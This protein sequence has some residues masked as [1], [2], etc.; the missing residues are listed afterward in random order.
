MHWIINST[1]KGPRRV[2]QAAVFCDNTIYSF[3]GYSHEVSLVELKFGLPID[4][5]A[6][7][8]SKDEISRFN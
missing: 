1:S 6:L 7:N 4:V 3:G 5:Y 2:N 8:T